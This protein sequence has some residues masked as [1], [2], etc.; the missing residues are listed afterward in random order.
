MPAA[1]SLTKEKVTKS[2]VL[3]SFSII[4]LVTLHYI[5]CTT[6]YQLLPTRK[7]KEKK[8]KRSIVK[9]AELSLR[10]DTRGE[11]RRGEKRRKERKAKERKRIYIYI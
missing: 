6:T 1:S 3:H 10:G 7:R 2:I 8:R 4:N 9:L 5:T 11:E